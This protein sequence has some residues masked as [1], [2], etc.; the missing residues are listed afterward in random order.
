MEFNFSGEMIEW[1]GPA[2][3]YYLAMPKSVCEEIRDVA[4][5]L[6]YGW[7]VIPVT[8]TIGNTTFTTS[9][10]PKDG[11]Y[12]LPVKNAVRIPEKLE[13]GAIV[14]VILEL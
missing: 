11:G 10:F 14:K 12:L 5:Q 2:P 9:L 3:F 6:S 1:R 7:G 13:L 4:K 8:A